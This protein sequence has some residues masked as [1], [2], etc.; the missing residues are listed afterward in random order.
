MSG[1]QAFFDA[2]LD[3][4]LQPPAGLTAWNGSDVATR[5]AVHRNNVTVSLIDALAETCPVTQE[6][7]GREF[8]R[9]MARVFISAVP[10][11]TKVLAFYGEE[12]PGFIEGF[13]PAGPVPYLADV[14]RLEILRVHAFHA[15]DADRLPA[16]ALEQALAR[17]D[18]L[19]G[20][21][22]VL[23]PSLGLLRSRYAVVSLWAAHQG[24]ADLSGVDPDSA[25]NALVIRPQLDVEVIGLKPGAADFVARLMQGQSLGFA[26]GQAGEAHA[27]FDL[28]EAVGL[29]VQHQCISSFNWQA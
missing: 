25:E 16:D 20:T 29:L 12:L 24:L 15:R 22:M 26:A 11:R 14:A 9:A 13:A 10:P 23:H 28:A 3:P 19:P 6:L 2:L 8:F 17:V 18:D 1:Q 27:D 21:S 7:V 5:F 4:E